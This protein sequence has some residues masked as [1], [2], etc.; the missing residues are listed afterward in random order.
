MVGYGDWHLGIY[1]Y[2]TNALSW[3]PTYKIELEER[4]EKLEQ[5]R[6]LKAGWDIVCSCRL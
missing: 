4:I 2:R 1:G 5:L 6:W 3:Y